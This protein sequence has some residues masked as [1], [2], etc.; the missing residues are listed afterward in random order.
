[1]I[2]DAEKLEADW[3]AGRRFDMCVIGTGPAGLSLARRLAGHGLRV[4]LMEGGDR[5]FTD[6]SQRIYDGENV[7]VDYFPLNATRYRFLGGS[8]NCW[9]GWC[10]AFD[11]E[12]FQPVKHHAASGWPITKT[13]LDPYFAETVA[14]LD[15]DVDDPMPA[16]SFGADSGAFRQI[17]FKFS[18]DL[19][20]APRFEPE[21]DA[22]KRIELFL[23]ANLVD[24]ELDDNLQTVRQGI[25]RT[26]ARP[27]PFRVEAKAFALCLGGLE[28]PRFLLNANRQVD[29]G[30]GNQHDLVGRYFSEHPHQT[31]GYMLLREPMQACEFYA[32]KRQWKEQQEI[33]G[34]SLYFSPV[35]QLTFT[36]ELLRSTVCNATFLKRL[37]EA[38]NYLPPT[39]YYGGLENFW[40]QW[41]DPDLLL[42]GSLSI[43]SEQALDPESR[44]RLG[45]DTDRFGLRRIELDWRLNDL[46][47]QTIQTA[48]MTFGE[49]LAERNVGRLKMADWLV[50]G[51]GTLPGT[52]VAQV[53]GRHH[54]CTTR[55]S[56]SPR[57]GVVDR[58]CRV[59]GMHNL[60]IGG[61]S[62]FSTGG[63]ANPTFTIVQLAMRLADHLA[64]SA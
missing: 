63:Y 23:N 1:M 15:V 4:A 10:R 30:I 43:A 34:F 14:F 44:V 33:L 56:D 22:S 37:A 9:G 39:C 64:I 6:E 24:L 40:A 28:N 38:I 50:D 47:F 20:L 29:T 45:D 49:L 25:F 8:S 12:D 26:Y 16:S 31:V 46:D 52:D 13:D 21:L 2:F 19:L 42:T 62:V 35:R 53:G 32:P 55:M 60:Y 5:T 41:R 27:E 3:F 36:K 58:D 11:A 18:Q 48:T 57:S 17:D 59:H 7:G 51:D 61:S 54:M